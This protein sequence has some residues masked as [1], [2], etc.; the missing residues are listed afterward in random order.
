MTIPPLS[1]IKGFLKAF[2]KTFSVLSEVDRKLII[3]PKPGS[4]DN[5][6]AITNPENLGSVSQLRRLTAEKIWIRPDVPT[7]LTL[8]IGHEEKAINF[9][10]DQVVTKLAV[11]EASIK[12]CNIQSL[13]QAY[14]GWLLG[15]HPGM[16]PQHMTETLRVNPRL[17]NYDIDCKFDLVKMSPNERYVR[18]N[19]ARAMFIYCEEEKQEDVSNS[20]IAIYN[21]KRP[22]HHP[23]TDYPDGRAMK[24]VPGNF[25]LPTSIGP[26]QE[27]RKDFNRRKGIQIDIN[28]I[29]R[30]NVVRINGLLEADVAISIQNPAAHGTQSATIKQL[31]MAIKSREDYK[32]PIIQK[33]RRR[34]ILRRNLFP[35]LSQRS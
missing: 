5:I 32:T 19:A 20:L 15:S 16:D 28:E 24:F 35:R 8:L 27:Q 21:K 17:C 31:L 29:A 6:S 23:G 13:E 11:F 9:T 7:P 14:V 3:L 4:S 2:K 18:D 30:S 25:G 26:T 34:A 33:N 12:I 10:C 1:E 22:A